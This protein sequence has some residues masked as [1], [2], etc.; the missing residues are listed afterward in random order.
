MIT[1]SNIDCKNNTGAGYWLL[2]LADGI[3]YQC[4]SV[5]YTFTEESYCAAGTKAVY[6]RLCRQE[7]QSIM[8][9]VQEGTDSLTYLLALAFFLW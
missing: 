5:I 3:L 1:K 4:I 6:F 7:T 2:I 9:E 8:E